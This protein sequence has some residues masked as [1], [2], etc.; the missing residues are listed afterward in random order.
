MVDARLYSHTRDISSTQ[1]QDDYAFHTTR[2]GE[3][4]SQVPSSE[5]DDTGQISPGTEF[6]V[7]HCSLCVSR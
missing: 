2:V 3:A 5:P 6:G 1:E 7:D 4:A